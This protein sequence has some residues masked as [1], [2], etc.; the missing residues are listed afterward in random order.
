MELY[1]HSPHGVVLYTQGQNY[2]TFKL[3]Y[4]V[5]IASI[6]TQRKMYEGPIF[7]CIKMTFTRSFSKDDVERNVTNFQVTQDGRQ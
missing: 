1:L 3:I 5:H 7:V 2:I 4:A 6:S